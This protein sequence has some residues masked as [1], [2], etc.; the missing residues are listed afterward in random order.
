[1]TTKRK[2]TY[3]DLSFQMQTEVRKIEN[4]LSNRQYRQT[5]N[6]LVVFLDSKNIMGMSITKKNIVGAEACFVLNKISM[7]LN[8]KFNYLTFV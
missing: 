8:F 1:M 3:D 6:E 5:P 4:E 7:V 2:Y